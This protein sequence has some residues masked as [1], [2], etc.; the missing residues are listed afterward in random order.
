MNERSKLNTANLCIVLRDFKTM[1]DLKLNELYEKI[2][3]KID[4]HMAKTKS[5]EDGKSKQKNEVD[6][7]FKYDDTLENNEL[8]IMYK[9]QYTNMEDDV[10]KEIFKDVSIQEEIQLNLFEELK[11]K[12]RDFMP[13]TSFEKIK[14]SDFFKIEAQSSGYTI[15]MSFSLPKLHLNINDQIS[16]TETF[17][18]KAQKDK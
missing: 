16:T 18:I 6:R 4:E 3:I 10:L 8:T 12:F 13:A 17:C 5:N 15:T 14:M 9:A 1:L 7:S 11:Q 2:N